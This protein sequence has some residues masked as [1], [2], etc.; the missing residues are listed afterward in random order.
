MSKQNVDTIRRAIETWNGEGPSEA[1]VNL[2]HPEGVLHPFP[3]WPDDAVY[4]GREGWLRLIEQWRE[5]F[6]QITWDI[7]RLIDID[8]AVVAL[9]THRATIRG[10]GIELS[11]PLGL[12]AGGF[13]DG[14]VVEAHFFLTWEE[15]LKAAGIED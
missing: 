4:R 13:S 15:A 14:M 8:P 3:E 7:E 6:D 12:V 2:A 10:S 11:Q 5:T 9:V 1:I